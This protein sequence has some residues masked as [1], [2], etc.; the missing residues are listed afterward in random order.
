MRRVFWEFPLTSSFVLFTIIFYFVT[1]AF[2]PKEIIKNYFV[3]YPGHFIPL[4]WL[5]STFFHGSPMHLLSNM[6][7]L[8]FLGRIVEDK[9]GKLKWLFFYLM[10]GIISAITDSVIRGFIVSGYNLPTVGASGAISGIAAVSALLSPFSFKILGKTMLFPVFLVSWVM[11]YSDLTGFSST[12]DY[13]AHYSHLGGFFSVFITA[14][15]LNSADRRKLRNGFYLNLTFFV[16]T[17][18][19][20]YFL[21]ER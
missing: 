14:Y 6:A 8:F 4:N 19:L 11:I 20:L 17:V 18:I 13:V 10:A 21:K 15:F 2:V 5:L 9:V 16:L 12:T 1:I 7:Y 3:S